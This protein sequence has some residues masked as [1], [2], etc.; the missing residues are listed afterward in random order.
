MIMNSYKYPQNAVDL[1][2]HRYS[3]YQTVLLSYSDISRCSL[4]IKTFPL[5]L[6]QATYYHASTH[7]YI[8]EVSSKVFS[9]R[10][11]INHRSN[12]MNNRYNL[13]VVKVDLPMPRIVAKVCKYVMLAIITGCCIQSALILTAIATRLL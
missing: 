3:L 2:S 6:I 8:S 12:I 7:R 13:Q 11:L 5:C 1:V 9:P 10:I 4:T